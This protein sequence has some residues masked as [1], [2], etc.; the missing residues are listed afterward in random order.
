M[1]APMLIP[2]LA[3]IA[4]ILCAMHGVGAAV[5]CAAI[6]LGC[7]I[8]ILL[9]LL[10]R[11]PVISYKLK[12]YYFTWM[13]LW[14]AG[15][16]II[17]YDMRRPYES[18]LLIKGC[19]STAYG[20]I[21]DIKNSTAGDRLTVNVSQLYDRSGKSYKSPNLK[22]I[23]R[24]DAVSKNVD[25]LIFFPATFSRITDNP[26]SFDDSYANRLALSG[27]YYQ[28]NASDNNIFLAGHHTTLRGISTRL[29]DRIIMAIEHSALSTKTRNFLITILLGD[30]SYLDPDLR[31]G[32][33]D[34]GISHV[35]A[36]SGMHIG[37]IAGILLFLLFP[38]NFKG[39]YKERLLIVGILL[40]FYA[41]V[42]GMGYSTIRACIMSA[43]M[44]ICVWLER[45]NSSW[46]ALLI[47]VFLI[48][49]IDPSAIFDVG[50][51]L[52]F[53]CVASLIFFS[54]PLNRVSQHDHPKLY[55]FNAMLICSL[56]AT[57]GSWA[58]TAY[59]FKTFPP[60]F[61]IANLIVLPLLPIYLSVAIIYLLISALGTDF[62]FLATIIDGGY[63]LLTTFVAYLN[64]L[65]SGSIY[66]RVPLTTPI[67]WIVGLALSATAI[68]TKGVRRKITAPLGILTLLASIIIGF[69]S[70]DNSMQYMVRSHGR[71]PAIV[72]CY[73]GKET[74][75]KFKSNAISSY[76]C[77]GK[78]IYAIDCK[79]DGY[80]PAKPISCD[81]LII[82][83]S[84]TSSLRALTKTIKPNQ[85]MLHPTMSRK[86][87]NLIKLE[88]DSMNIT[89]FS[90]RN[91]NKKIRLVQ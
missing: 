53:L 48:L 13:A 14:F 67:L 5:G 15:I 49:I 30:R 23:L 57:F 47:A 56:V 73:K 69:G 44:I 60:T 27:I 3:L 84:Y 42:S 11:N 26:D 36:L 85:I 66:L 77:N 72:Q 78:T 90:L 40:F 18:D 21:I 39:W 2:V 19:Y 20:R 17:I 62:E 76:T 25:D 41:F 34:A 74:E 32:F 71:I 43:C 79:L 82:T 59:W 4:G 64:T 63:N 58:V 24:S 80:R 9:A 50:L 8:Y 12:Q 81:Y 91:A 6:L 35:L 33:A 51:Q 55:K 38:M 45:R 10:S 31:A 54:R 75:L 86:K 61:L 87:G 16:G 22:V 37:I 68:S 7:A 89:C 46:N 29:R 28:C 70:K 88:A 65:S 1:Y 52:S 83:K